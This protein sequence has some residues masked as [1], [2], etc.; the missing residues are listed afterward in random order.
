MAKKIIA[1]ADYITAS[2]SAHLLSS[3]MGRPISPK[4]IR[5]LANRKGNPVHVQAMGNRLLY[6]RTDIESVVI[7]QYKANA[8]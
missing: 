4:Y 8:G 7:R 5:K 3:K 6:C 1:L 2:E